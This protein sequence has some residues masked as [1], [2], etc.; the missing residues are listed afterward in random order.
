[1][2]VRI[3]QPLSLATI[4]ALLLSDGQ[5]IKFLDANALNL[6]FTE[7]IKEIND[8]QPEIFILTSTPIDRW[9]CPN[10]HIDFIFKIINSVKV[11]SKILTGSHGTVTPEW[12]FKKCQID[13]IIRSEPEMTVQQLVNYLKQKGDWQSLAGISYR[14]DD[15]IINN[16]PAERIKNLDD[17][18]IPAYDLLPMVRYHNSAY[19]EPF[20]IMMTSRGCP[21]NCI[22]CLKVMAPGLYLYQ[23]A[24]RVIKEIEYLIKS[25]Q[26]KSIFFQDWE[27]LI[28]SDRVAEICELIKEKNLKFAW[29]C[30]SRA[31]DIIKNPQLISL[32][33]AAGCFKINLGLE[34]ASDK[35]LNNINKKI[36]QND[37]AQAINILKAASIEVGYYVLLNCPGEDEATIKETVNFILKNKIKVKNFNP[38]IPYPG[39]QLFEQLKE[40]YPAREFNWDNIEESAGLVKTA[41]KPKT[42]LLYLRNY[43]YQKKYSY[44]YFLNL[45]FWRDF[46]KKRL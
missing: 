39:T 8:F 35:I 4:A 15:K 11:K 25:F 20:T 29:G 13:F 9:E 26:I 36:T 18:P 7:I 34:S 38:V 42:A 12:I 40:Q 22:F 43:K 6:T 16:P 37:L 41:L 17:L 33:K 32:M 46:F 5:E 14:L 45:K 2:N 10:S 23:S 21:Y 24:Q 27:F 30:N 44:F 1:M 3:R 19:P 31:T 28:N